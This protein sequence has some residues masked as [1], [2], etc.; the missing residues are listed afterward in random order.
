[1]KP[2]HVKNA[3]PRYGNCGGKCNPPP[4]PAPESLPSEPKKW[5]G[6]TQGSFAKSLDQRFFHADRRA[7]GLKGAG[8]RLQS[9]RQLGL[10]IE[11]QGAP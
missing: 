10:F 9:F 11:A 6:R 8:E 7:L 5:R 4:Q 2:Q 1:M 3:D